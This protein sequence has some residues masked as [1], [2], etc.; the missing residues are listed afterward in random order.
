MRDCT[1]RFSRISLRS[2]RLRLLKNEMMPEPPIEHLAA[3]VE[4]KTEEPNIEYKAWMDL[5]DNGNRA[6]IARHL[7][8]L[9]NLGGGYLIFGVDDDGSFAEPHPGDLHPYRQDAI[10]NIAAKYLAPPPHCNVHFV[11]VSNGKEYPVVTV[12]SH[13]AQPIC[14]KSDG[15]LVKG[16]RVGVQQGVHY[17]RLAGPRTAAIDTPDLWQQVL[18]RCVL[19]ERDRLVSAIGGLLEK[20]Q[21]TSAGYSID[22]LFDELAARWA[23]LQPTERWTVD[24]IQNRTIYAFQLLDEARA[25]VRE[26]GLGAL[27]ESVRRATFDAERFKDIELSAFASISE[28]SRCGVF[29]S[30]D[31]E[32][33]ELQHVHQN[34]SY[35]RPPVLGHISAAGGGG[36][37]RAYW[38]DTTWVKEA[39]E[40]RSSR[41]WEPGTKLSPSI[42]VSRALNFIAF[43]KSLSH[44]FPDARYAML[45]ADYGGLRGRVIGEPRPGV[46]FSYDRKSGMASR[47]AST[48]IQLD[49]LAEPQ[50]AE[51]AA[52]LTAPIF[53]LFD[54][55]QI[56]PDFASKLLKSS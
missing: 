4:H 16:K 20:P 11:P 19:K 18:H 3:L 49:A 13:G 44:S 34:G 8:G 46:Y 30:G 17:I 56:V 10:N 55:W 21:L 42:Q 32:G 53:R 28:N 24:L 12:P 7:C 31:V 26:I 5:S 35:L 9:A 2:I 15:P 45:S 38:E 33:Y 22:P 25:I 27:R 1:A 50:I 41:K 40:Q 39:V 43:V 6:N 47:R 48:V 54:G 36:E 37:V 29:V 23:E 51:A 14:A 52:D